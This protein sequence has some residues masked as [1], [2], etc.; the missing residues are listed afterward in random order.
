MEAVQA[1]LVVDS[2]VTEVTRASPT[3]TVVDEDDAPHALTPFDASHLATHGGDVTPFQMATNP[4]E[5]VTTPGAR[6]TTSR[7]PSTPRLLTPVTTTRTP[8]T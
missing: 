5:L 2:A 8:S 7:R 6:L 4:P 3:S 1:A